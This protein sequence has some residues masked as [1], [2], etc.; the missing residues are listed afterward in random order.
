MK[1]E[2]SGT[3]EFERTTRLGRAAL[4]GGLAFLTTLALGLSEARAEGAPQGGEGRRQKQGLR[5]RGHAPALKRLAAEL[6]LSPDQR[7]QIQGL[8]QEMR[9]DLA[10]EQAQLRQLG[11]QLRAA[12]QAPEPQ[13]GRI[14]E[15]RRQVNAVHGTIQARRVQF[16]LSVY[17]LLTPEQRVRLQ[18]MLVEQARRGADRRIDTQTLQPLE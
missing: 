6:Q 8:R 4:V 5:A 3:R 17:R 12:W 15:L 1:R 18:Q 7:Q 14:L 13:G 16:R 10:D 9:R 11:D 2:M